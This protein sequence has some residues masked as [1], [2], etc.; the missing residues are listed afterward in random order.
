MATCSTG[1]SDTS[2]AV[3][4]FRDYPIHVPAGP[5]S[6]FVMMADQIRL[7][8]LGGF[9]HSHR[10]MLSDFLEPKSR[11]GRSSESPWDDRKGPYLTALPNF[12]SVRV[13]VFLKSWAVIGFHVYKPRRSSRKCNA[14]FSFLDWRGSSE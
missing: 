4:V 3:F 8:R 6:F 13:L 11:T 12:Y 1:L 14:N 9:S 10:A 7:V 2:V 5:R